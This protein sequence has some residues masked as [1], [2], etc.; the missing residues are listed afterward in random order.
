MSSFVYTENPETN[1]YS[2]KEV[3]SNF[4]C[5]PET[6]GNFVIVKNDTGF[7]LE[8]N[9][10]VTIEEL[11]S[12][13][14]QVSSP[15]L[16]VAEIKID[17]IARHCEAS[18]YLEITGEAFPGGA[19]SGASLSERLNCDS[20]TSYA[21]VSHVLNEPGVYSVAYHCDCGVCKS[22]VYLIS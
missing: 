1:D 7:T 18:S 10:V 3:T 17:S 22:K 12:E 11:K 2:F 21:S 19:P 6:S 16:I 15:C 5:L 13:S 9:G 8:K 14:F 20:L 4:V